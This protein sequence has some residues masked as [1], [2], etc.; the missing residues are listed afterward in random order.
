MPPSPQAVDQLLD[1][2]FLTPDQRKDKRIQF[3][4][5]TVEDL[6]TPARVARAAL[7]RG[8]YDDPSLVAADADPLDRAEAALRRGDF[9]A[10]TKELGD[11]RTPR[12]VRVRVEALDHL[13]RFDDATNTAKPLIEALLAGNLKTAD[14][15]AEGVRVLAI[16]TRLRGPA[17]AGN[18]PADYTAMMQLLAD[19]RTR[20]D[21]LA[22]PVIL[23]EAELLYDKDNR[24]QAAE[25]LEQVLTLNPTS[26]DA[27]TLLGRLTVDSFNFGSTEKIARRLD[28]LAG[29]WTGTDPD[30]LGEDLPGSV[31]P[32]AAKLI[33]RTQLRQSEGKL[34]LEVLGPAMAR[35]P[36]MPELRALKCAA[37]AVGFDFASADSCLE[38]FDRA[39]GRS[40]LAHLAVGSALSEARQYERSRKHLVEAARRQPMDAEPHITL[41][42]MLLQAG[43]DMG[44][45]AAL[46][47]SFALDPFNVRADNSLRLARELQTYERVETPHYVIRYKPGKRP[48]GT[49]GDELLACEMAGPLEANHAAVTGKPESGVRGG[50]DHVPAQKTIIDLMPDHQWFGVRI[51][52]MPAIHTIAA[53][54]GPVIAME[55]P[56]EGPKHQGSYDWV[57]VLR[58]EYVHTVTLS[59]TS[60]RIPHWFTEASAVFLENAPR[61]FSTVQLLTNVLVADKLF[62]FTD[63]NIAFVRPRRPSDR[64]QAYAQGHWMY[65]YICARFGERAPLDLMD[66]Y[67]AGVREEEAFSS[68]LGIGRTQFFEDFKKWARNQV[69]EWGMLP[70]EGE[71]TLRALLAKQ[72]L[73]KPDLEPEVRASLER[74]AAGK[75]EESDAEVELVEATPELVKTL[76]EGHPTHPDVLELA[77]DDAVKSAGGKATAEL[78]PLI[79]RYARARSVDPKPHRLLARMYLEAAD[80]DPSQLVAQAA[81]AIP[82]LEFLDSREQKSPTL[83]MELARRHAAIGEMDKAKI[84]AERAT[85]LSPF[86]PRP[87]ELAAT[88]ALQRK[89]FVSAERHIVALTKIEPD[90]D[91]HTRRLEALSRMKAAQPSTDASAE[92]STGR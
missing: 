10:V 41:G 9:E 71:P 82:H 88:I 72:T 83:S 44:A 50:I 55:S 18:S 13:S 54:T 89:D 77:V 24:G 15:I 52:G 78:V 75:E 12:A 2:A 29:D 42:L 25:A 38:E 84:K 74:I 45:L 79:E 46:E 90:R 87:R 23:V 57:R 30:D 80:A 27:W 21:R 86:D 7:I 43:D 5:Y 33:A 36:N 16:R 68:V 19:A 91:I 73:I 6:D 51:A 63:I 62:D 26:A 64:S 59:R 40:P 1:A 58:H 37:E 32:Q 48:D 28:L 20:L 11:L 39:H 70:P 22:W 53:S 8:A 66:K 49:A 31:S 14:E 85:Q 34:A 4:R 67:A 76:L 3:G 61:D 17:Q 47:K 81:A 60:N 92:P 35:Y 69:I 56:R 65:E